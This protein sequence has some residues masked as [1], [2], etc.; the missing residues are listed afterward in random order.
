MSESL[1]N[2]FS[3]L[4]N[5]DYWVRKDI[6]DEQF[7]E[8]EWRDTTGITVKYDDDGNLLIPRRDLRAL[9]KSPDAEMKSDE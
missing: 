9:A 1:E 7:P 8:L 2:F 4:E 3:W 6:V 5:Q